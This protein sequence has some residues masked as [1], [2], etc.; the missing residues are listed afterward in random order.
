MV[1]F[2]CC[3]YRARDALKQC[4]PDIL[5]NPSFGSQFV[6]EESVQRWMSLLKKNVIEVPGESPPAAVSGGAALPPPPG[7]GPP[8]GVSAP[9]ALPKPLN[10]P[11]GVGPPPGTL[12]Y[13][14]AYK[15]DGGAGWNT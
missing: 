13:G 14:A 3:C 10:G 15:R 1:S 4:L 6:E 2:D 12:N 11:P 7:V 5:K 9:P 8:P